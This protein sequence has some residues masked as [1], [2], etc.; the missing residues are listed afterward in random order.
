MRGDIDHLRLPI[1]RQP[2]HYTAI[3]LNR[4]NGA[5]LYRAQCTAVHAGTDVLLDFASY[6]LG[7]RVRDD[8][9]IW[10]TE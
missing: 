6:E 9:V 10:T 3:V 1:E 2:D 5:C 4:V 7:R 8:D